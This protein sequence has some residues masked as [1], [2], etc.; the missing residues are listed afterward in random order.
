MLPEIA[1]IKLNPYILAAHQSTIE[2][3]VTCQTRDSR[4]E[5]FAICESLQDS[6][7]I[8]VIV[9]SARTYADLLEAAFD[10][11][12]FALYEAL[13]GTIMTNLPGLPVY[14]WVVIL[15]SSPINPFS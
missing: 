5:N 4:L 2:Y 14:S 1:T 11:Y 13:H 12:R 3:G 6:Q 10:L 15:P 8:N 7:K 9:Q